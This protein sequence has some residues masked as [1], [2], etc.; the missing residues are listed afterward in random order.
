VA[1]AES[2]TRAGF[3]Q[4]FLNNGASPPEPAIECSALHTALHVVAGTRL[5]AVAPDAVARSYAR[6]GMIVVLQGKSL[7]LGRSTVS[8]ITRRDSEA[9]PVIRQ[10]RMALMASA[11]HG[12]AA[13]R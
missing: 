8:V 9:L 7:D 2:R 11:R 13:G 10:F 3:L 5:L 6:K 12:R 4:L 1:R